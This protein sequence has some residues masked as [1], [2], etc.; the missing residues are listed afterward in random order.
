MAVQL[1]TG[2]GK[3]K[4][5]AAFGLALRAAGHGKRVFI[6]QFMKGRMYG[7][8]QA[9]SAIPNIAVVQFGWEACIRREDVSEFHIQRTRQG[10]DSC[11]ERAKCG[12]Y[13]VLVLDEILVAQW[14]GLVGLE[15]LAGFIARHRHHAELV[16]TGRRA[17]PELVE[18]A[19]L[20]TEM[21]CVKHP[22]DSG[23][24]A[25]EGIEY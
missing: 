20:V 22:F 16:L 13:D 12:R 4:T 24:P 1:Y 15:D 25:R 19:D 17:A 10:L 11:N 23:V 14:F 8:L 7:E 9:V 2:D 6:A 3:G 21:A 18:L 5:T